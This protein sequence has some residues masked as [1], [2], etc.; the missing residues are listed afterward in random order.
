MELS[1]IEISDVIISKYSE[2]Q[3]GVY[4]HAQIYIGNGLFFHVARIMR[5]E[6]WEAMKSNY[7]YNWKQINMILGGLTKGTYEKI[8]KKKLKITIMKIFD[9][10]LIQ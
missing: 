7:T 5:G 3:N 6:K 4:G 8:S 1:D 10:N 9:R 2:P